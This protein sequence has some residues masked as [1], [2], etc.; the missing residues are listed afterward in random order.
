MA[1]AAGLSTPFSLLPCIPR[2]PP[3]NPLLVLAELGKIIRVYAVLAALVVLGALTSWLAQS[4]TWRR[5]PDDDDTMVPLIGPNQLFRVDKRAVDP[6]A[7]R[8]GDLVAYVE[9]PRAEESLALGRVA[10]LPGERIRIADGKIAVDGEA[11]PVLDAAE[12]TAGQVP[13]LLVPRG[14][15]YLLVEQRQG[16]EG[17]SRSRG[18]IAAARL[19]GRVVR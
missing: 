12:R 19:L 14:H 1:A 13:D 2:G 16:V 9:D 8:R 18:P 17:D 10:A 7:L 3:Y 6:S 5:V 15:V 11:V 4:F